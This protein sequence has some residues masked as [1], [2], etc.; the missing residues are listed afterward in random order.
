[1]IPYYTNLTLNLEFGKYN[2][3]MSVEIFDDIQQLVFLENV[4]ENSINLAYK[5]TLPTKIKF[6]LDN[7]NPN[8]DTKLDAEGNVIKD[9]YVRLASMSLGGIPIKPV[10]LFKIC[11]YTANHQIKFDTYWGT[12]GSAEIDFNADYFIKWHLKTNNLFDL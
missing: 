4:T 10:V 12:N 1:M 7:K 6:N 11:K 9:K 3:S 8:R 2:G 5:I